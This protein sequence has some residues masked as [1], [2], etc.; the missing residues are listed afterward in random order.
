MI[1]KGERFY[2]GPRPLGKLRL[3]L[4]QSR[5]KVVINTKQEGYA[6]FGTEV[7]GGTEPIK[8]GVFVP[9]IIGDKITSYVSLQ[10]IDREYAFSDSH[11]RLLETLSNSM[12]VALENARLF[13]EGL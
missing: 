3:H 11:I 9:L 4:I 12:S 1:E 6:W 8:S 2:P 10:N 13:D 5:K 7:V